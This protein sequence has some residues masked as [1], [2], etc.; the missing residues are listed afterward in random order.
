M[1]PSKNISSY[2]IPYTSGLALM[3]SVVEG[4]YLAGIKKNCDN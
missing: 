1:N 2:L 4:E 3:P